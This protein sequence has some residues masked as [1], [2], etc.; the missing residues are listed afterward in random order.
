M[1]L[2]PTAELDMAVADM[3]VATATRQEGNPLGGRFLPS[4]GPFALEFH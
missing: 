1:A 4:V 3:E 2:L